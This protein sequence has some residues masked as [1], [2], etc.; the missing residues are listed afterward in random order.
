MAANQPHLVDFS[1]T[2]RLVFLIDLQPLIFQNQ[3]AYIATV[4][5]AASRLLRFPP[6]SN[7][8]FAYKL[9][10]SSLSPLR[11]ADVL[12]RHLCS[13]SLSFKFPL[14][15]LASLSTNLNSVL[16]LLDLPNPPGSPLALH[17]HSALLQLVHDYGWENDNEISV[18]RDKSMFSDFLK[19]PSNLV[20][21]FSPL[22]FLLDSISFHD[23]EELSVKFDGIFSAVREAFLSRDMHVCWNDVNSDELQLENIND[24]KLDNKYMTQSQVLLNCI[25]KMGWG[26][27]S[28]NW[29]VLGSA[30]LPF[31]LIYPQIGLPFDFVDFGGTDESKCGGQLN[32]EI[33]DTK[34]MPLEYKC[35]D[36]EFVKLKSLSSAIRNNN[37]FGNLE[38]RD[39]QGEDHDEDSFLSQFGDGSLKL[40][41]KAVLGHPELKKIRCYSEHVFVREFLEEVGKGGKKCNGDFFADRVLE[42]LHKD[43]GIVHYSSQIPTWKFFLSFLHTNGFSAVVS[44]LSA[45]GHT[46][47]GILKPFTA[48]LAILSILD[49]GN[50]LSNC[51]SQSKLRKI[52][53]RVRD[54]CAEA[55]PDSIPYFDSQTE[56]STSGNYEKY[57]V[58]KRKKKRIQ[59]YQQMTWSSFCKAAFEGSQMDLFEVYTAG[60]FENSKK[61]KFLKCWM[62]QIEKIDPYCLT[63]LLQSQSTEEFSACCVPSAM[64][65]AMLTSSSE[66]SESFFNN[67]PKRIQQGL[68][69]GIDLH[70][71]AQRVVKSSIHWLHENRATKNDHIDQS[72]MQIQDGSCNDAFDIKLMELILREPKEMK[73]MHQEQDSPSKASQAPCSSE[74]IVRD[75]ELQIFLRLEIMR[76]D[77]S[78]MIEESRKQKL[79]KQICSLLEIIQYLVAGGIHGPISLYDYVERS[80]KARYSEELGDIVR[81]I[82]TKMDFLPFGDEDEAP[83]LSLFNS[84]DSNQSW[85]DKHEKA[86]AYSIS[87]SVSEEDKYSNCEENKKETGENDHS[88]MLNKARER[89]ERARRFSSFTGRVQDLQRVWA[90]KQQQKIKDKLDSLPKKSKRKDWHEPGSSVVHETPLTGNKRAGTRQDKEQEDLGNSYSVSKA[91]FQDIFPEDKSTA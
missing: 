49:C 18:G 33:L 19:I 78:A 2:Q 10:F 5:S 36:L 46:R 79:L 38:L 52:E 7:S 72:Q 21:L 57:A 70:I 71:L 42:S 25:R 34:G 45:N 16:T 1:K 43:M 44:L 48:H 61:L 76:S 73:E 74:N 59:L 39:S 87:Q 69:S 86:E 4:T 31:G 37:A 12:P 8:L 54:T 58:G 26:F 82:Y 20:L 29:I 51:I 60:Q 13:P 41:V 6:L 35:C 23:S 55:L 30:L 85:K 32:L 77:V 56:S 9:F 90:P 84:E 63:T 75:Y 91:L 14:Q 66:S 65:E 62:K 53:D 3:S 80:I 15:T 64:E 24:E 11:S 40:Y 17:I 50:V 22:K 81:K 83:S 88:Q 28:T 27:C 47:I 89:R 67:L 68:E